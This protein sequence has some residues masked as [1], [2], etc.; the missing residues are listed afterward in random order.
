MKYKRFSLETVSHSC[1]LFGRQQSVATNWGQLLFE[2]ALYWADLVQEH[3]IMC[4]H[5]TEDVCW[6]CVPFKR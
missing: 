2:L 5:E 1:D 6:S 4:I 3:N